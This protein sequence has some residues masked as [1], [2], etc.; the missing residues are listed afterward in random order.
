[1]GSQL[2]FLAMRKVLAGLFVFAGMIAGIGLIS[3]IWGENSPIW[4]MVLFV[5]LYLPMVFALAYFLFNLG[6]PRPWSPTAADIAHRLDEQGLLVAKQFRAVRALEVVDEFED[7]GLSYLLE[8]ESGGVL[9]LS[10]QYLYGYDARTD[11][12]RAFPSTEFTL[13]VHKEK[14]HVVDIV[15]G[16]TLLEPELVA[17]P[18]H[19]VDLK[20]G[21]AP[22]DGEIIRD[23]TFDEI[24][25]YAL[26]ALLK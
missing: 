26:R 9:F 8:L 22:E 13:R 7:E 3:R 4:T 18:F 21:K 17:T 23:R 15:C 5:G 16:G 19:D 10:G 12:A 2:K 1:M 6:V 25:A 24:K 11:R 14:G 20:D